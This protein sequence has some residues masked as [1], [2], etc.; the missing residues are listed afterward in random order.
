MMNMNLNRFTH[1]EELE[2]EKNII[3]WEIEKMGEE[4]R[5]RNKKLQIA[6][7]EEEKELVRQN[8]VLHG[9]NIS[10]YMREV[11]VNSLII[12]RDFSDILNGLK[13]SGN[14]INEITKRV[15]IQGEVTQKDVDE[16]RIEY[17]NMLELAIE[18][19]IT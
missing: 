9:Q 15:N 7:S 19:I 3:G 1:G 14:R 12:K 6:M 18:K 10:E 16:L 11:G 2:S 5:L 13:P 4:N 8:S 17:E